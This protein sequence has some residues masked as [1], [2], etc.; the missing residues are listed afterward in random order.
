[1]QNSVNFVVNLSFINFIYGS[2]A[3]LQ[4]AYVI[5]LF[6]I[7]FTTKNINIFRTVFNR[8][9]SKPQEQSIIK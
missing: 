4:K 1:M 9:V 5:I 8:V 7:L 6:V 3:L 2:L